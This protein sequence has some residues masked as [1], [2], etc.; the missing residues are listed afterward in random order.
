MESI[1]FKKEKFMMVSGKMIK[2]MD[3]EFT[4][5]LMEINMKEI[6]KVIKNTVK[7]TMSFLMD[8]ELMLFLKMV[9]KLK[10]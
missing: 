5:I 10:K 3:R 8:M 2:S 4:T 1:L 9:K 7:G 6:L